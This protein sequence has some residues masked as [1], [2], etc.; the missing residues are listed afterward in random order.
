[1]QRPR[2]QMRI[3][4][5]GSGAR[6]HALVWKLAQSSRVGEL[7]VAPG[8][9]GLRG[10]AESLDIAVTDIPGL[11]AAVEERDIDL[12]V[13]GPEAP[14]A[15]GLAD[16]LRERGRAVFGPGAA[17]ARIES[18]KAWAKDL[19]VEHGVPTARGVACDSLPAALIELEKMPGPVVVKADGLA[20]G[21]G[22]IVCQTHAEAAAALRSMLDE[23]ALGDAG[24]RVLIEECLVGPEVSFLAFVDGDTVVP[25]IPACDYKRAYDGDEGPNTGGMGAY[26]PTALVDAAMSERIVSEIV[27]PVVRGMA[28]RG[29]DYRGVLYAGLMLTDA[30]PKVIEFNC[31]FG[32]PETQVI[33]PLLDA[34]LAELCAAT[35]AGR[36]AELA[37]PAWRSGACVGIV[38]AAGGY[39][40]AYTNGH[41]IHGLDRLPE[42]GI[43]FHAGTARAGDATVTAGGRVVTAVGCGADMADARELA[44]ATAGAIG[45]EGAFCRRDIALREIFTT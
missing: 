1:M 24:S 45:F 35:A 23:H 17:G 43:V 11:V 6:E 10:L 5:V 13:V 16:E 14:L 26:S 27:G 8:N 18:S 21:K 4:V 39:P 41:A 34:D 29:I 12:V 15:A 2:S 42:G 36:L 19:M 28:A 40:G 32:D 33:L 37:P 20:A 38:V 22:V 25:L 3:L 44:Y 30:G 31:R 9:A 7:L